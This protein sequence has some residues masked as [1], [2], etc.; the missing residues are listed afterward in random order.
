MTPLR[1]RM[2]DDMR[3]RNFSPKSIK[4]Y[5]AGVRH[6]AEYFDRSP[7]Q[8]GIEHVRAYQVYLV[9]ERRVSWSYLNVIVCGLRFFYGTTL[10]RKEMAIRI[11]FAKRPRKLPCVLSREEV[12]RL[13]EAITNYSHRVIL[14]TTYAG[15]LRISEVLRLRYEDI[16]TDRMLIHIRHGKGGKDRYVPLS[17]LLL[18]VLQAY[19]KLTPKN[20]WLFPGAQPGH[21]LSARTIQRAI[22]RAVWR[23]G[24][25]KQATCHTLR[26]SF[27]T[28]LLESGTDI[29]TIQRLLGHK[30]LET[31]AIYTHV[32]DAQIR[33][34]KSPLDLIRKQLEEN[35]P[36]RAEDKLA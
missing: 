24:I 16:D 29:R 13:F 26:H 12:I 9:N 34:T 18:E 25:K 1:Q 27:A 30:N 5:V 20:Q 28:H 23:A 6:F 4:N 15:G 8:L 3:V 17:E 33:S 35:Q 22:G 14:M 31:T 36:H 11:P 10:G 2:V 7:D 19:Q 32:T 21:Y